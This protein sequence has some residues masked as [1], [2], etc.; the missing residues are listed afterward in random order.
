MKHVE[1]MREA[2]K[3]EL[4]GGT[5]IDAQ[6]VVCVC[7]HTHAGRRCKD[8]VVVEAMVVEARAPPRCR[9]GLEGATGRS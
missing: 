9:V 7:V 6:T 3:G 1:N 4:G 5:P 8:A 2:G